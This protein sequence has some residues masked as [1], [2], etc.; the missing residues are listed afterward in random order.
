M[1]VGV[2]FHQQPYTPTEFPMST[3]IGWVGGID[4]MKYLA[5]EITRNRFEIGQNYALR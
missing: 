1:M 4:L 3:S 2:G 5:G